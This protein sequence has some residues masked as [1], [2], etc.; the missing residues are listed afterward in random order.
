M[1]KFNHGFLSMATGNMAL[2][3][4]TSS[5]KVEPFAKLL[6][7]ITIRSKEAAKVEREKLLTQ[8]KLE[9]V[10]SA[11]VAKEAAFT[12]VKKE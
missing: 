10:E 5:L 2:V 1:L 8:I 4:L 6:E 12:I 11:F 3:D 7:E 9:V